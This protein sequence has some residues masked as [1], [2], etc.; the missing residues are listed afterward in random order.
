M[1]SYLPAK[2]A[3]PQLYPWDVYAELTKLKSAKAC[4]PDE[5]PPKLVKEF[6]YELSV[7]LTDI[8]N[9]SYRE[10]CVPV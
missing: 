1:P 7:P 10:G 4:G 5:I 2:K 6:A 9:S 8:L 3:A